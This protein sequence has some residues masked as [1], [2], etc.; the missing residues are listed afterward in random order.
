MLAGRS[1][2]TRAAGVAGRRNL[3]ARWIERGE[4]RDQPPDVRRRRASSSSRARLLAS[5]WRR[6]SASAPA[7]FSAAAALVSAV[8]AL[9]SAV[10]AL[11]S[12]VAALVSAVAAFSSACHGAGRSM[13]RHQARKQWRGRKVVDDL[14]ARGIVVRSPSDR[15]VAEEAPGAYKDVADVVLAAEEAGLARRVARLKPVIVIKG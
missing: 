7:L 4:A 13:S 8:A 11:V 5:A 9:V 12:A 10:A 15:G 1:L 3:A 6:A 14:A 2:V